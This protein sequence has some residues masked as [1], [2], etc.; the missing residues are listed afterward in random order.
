[1][2][3]ECQPKQLHAINEG[4]RKDNLEGKMEFTYKPIVGKRVAGEV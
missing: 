1:M 4:F 3:V 2:V